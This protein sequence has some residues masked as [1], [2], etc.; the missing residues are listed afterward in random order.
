V[1]RLGLR[2]GLAI[3]ESIKSSKI[4]EI[5]KESESSPELAVGR[6]Y[7]MSEALSPFVGLNA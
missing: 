7:I 4:K 2:G 3:K 6:D 5:I 1:L